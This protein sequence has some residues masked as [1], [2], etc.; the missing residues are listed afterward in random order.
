MKKSER[1][2]LLRQI[3]RQIKNA[4]L[5]RDAQFRRLPFGLARGVVMQVNFQRDTLRYMGFYEIEL[6][7]HFRNLVH[8][9]FKCFD[10][11][12]K[13]GYDALLL[14]KLSG[15]IIVSFECDPMAA[16]TM[17][18][19][20]ARN[21][22]QISVIETFVS[23][24]S[25]ERCLTL[26]DAVTKTFIPDFVKIDIEGEEAKALLGAQHLLS[27]RTPNLLIEV[28]GMEQ[29]MLCLE[30]LRDCGYDP[31]LINQR[32]WLKENRPLLHNRW[33]VCQGRDP[34]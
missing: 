4:L 9:G 16:E 34:M 5:P 26:D 28:H 30:I 12:G 13:D 19:T 25:N 27:H 33:L 18:N 23:N 32:R 1:N 20:F 8:R 22:Y 2:V 24:E 14:A 31:M 15:G 17:R 3:A 11:G 21:P 10:V 29:E 7:K 6:S